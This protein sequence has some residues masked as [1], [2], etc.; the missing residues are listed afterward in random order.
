MIR[1]NYAWDKRN[2][3]IKEETDTQCRQYKSICQ[4]FRLSHPPPSKEN[5]AQQMRQWQWV[6]LAGWYEQRADRDGRGTG[7]ASISLSISFLILPWILLEV[8]QCGFI[9]SDI[10]DHMKW[11]HTM[12]TSH[13][14]FVPGTG[15]G[16]KL[17]Q[18]RATSW[19]SCW[20]FDITEK[21]I[22]FQKLSCS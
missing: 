21:K 13:T 8:W 3:S 19:L 5:C 7:A 16:V 22:M 17:E 12:A 18:G 2:I 1:I 10:Q 11:S 15:N 9:P 4:E 14:I 20:P 6:S